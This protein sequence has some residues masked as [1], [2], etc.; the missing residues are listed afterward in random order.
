MKNSSLAKALAQVI[1]AR[2]EKFGLSQAELA[3]KAGVSASYIQRLEYAERTLTLAV[4]L[5]LT[6]ALDADP[7]ELLQETLRLRAALG[8]S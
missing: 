4:F 1:R 8:G 7:A 2:R 6:T 3:K 5:D